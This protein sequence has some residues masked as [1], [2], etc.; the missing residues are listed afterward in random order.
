MPRNLVVC[1]AWYLRL[2]NVHSPSNNGCFF[3]LLRPCKH[4]RPCAHVRTI[5]CTR[6]AL[7]APDDVSSTNTLPKASSGFSDN[8]QRMALPTPI[9]T[10]RKCRAPWRSHRLCA[11]P[12]YEIGTMTRFTFNFFSKKKTDKL[13]KECDCYVTTIANVEACER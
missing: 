3:G 13:Q 12:K 5:L 4:I 7:A 10:C 6:S 8:A 11:C 2:Y 9:S 1:I